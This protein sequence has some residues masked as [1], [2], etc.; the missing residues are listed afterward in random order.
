MG[1]TVLE[2]LVGGVACWLE[3]GALPPAGHRPWPL[4]EPPWLMTQ[5]WE[6]LLFAHWPVPRASLEPLVPPRLAIDTFDGVAWLGIVPFRVTELRVRGLPRLPGV[7]RFPEINVRTYVTFGGKPGVWFFSLDAGRRLAVAGARRLYLLPYFLADMQVMPRADRIGYV[8]R[9]V[10]AGAVPAAFS[11][12]YQPVGVA[13]AAE[14]G[15]LAWFLTE[16]YCLY[17]ADRSGGIH[18]AEIHHRPW[19]LQPAEADIRTNT[20]V[21]GLGL[22]LEGAPLLHFSAVQ[23]VWVWPPGFVVAG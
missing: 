15:D 17:A 4:P 3:V 12:E 1:A 8:S 2:R 13:A 21:G 22:R 18:R 19:A 20:M 11:G 7:S 5:T 6:D 10:H 14:P 23:N 9:R 16:R